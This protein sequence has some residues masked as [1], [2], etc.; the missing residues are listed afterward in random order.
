MSFE[1]NVDADFAGCYNFLRHVEHKII[2]TARKKAMKSNMKNLKKVFGLVICLLLVLLCLAAGAEEG[3]EYHEGLTG[4]V[5]NLDGIT[6]EK[7]AEEYIRKMMYFQKGGH[8]VPRANDSLLLGSRLSGNARKLYDALKEKIMLVAEGKLAS[9]EFTFTMSQISDKLSY[10]LNELGYSSICDEAYEA[11]YRAIALNRDSLVTVILGAL[12]GDCSYELYWFDKTKGAGWTYPRGYYD[13]N[14]GKI[15]MD[16]NKTLTITMYVAKEYS[17]SNAIG[18]LTVNTSLGQ[19]V[20]KAAANAK[21]IVES[22]CDKSDYD[23][24]WT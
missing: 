19:A 14:T 9:T 24:L 6:N 23:K 22:N 8:S 12:L 10:T 20:Q 15:Q 21:A 4:S 17:A 18:T 7:A 13:P 11:Y 2:K 5:T 1:L 16:P 3:V